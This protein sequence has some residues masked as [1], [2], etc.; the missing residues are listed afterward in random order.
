MSVFACGG[1]QNTQCI[2][3]DCLRSK[4][5]LAK[6]GEKPRCISVAPD[7][8]AT[9][10]QNG[11]QG[12]TRPIQIDWTGGLHVHSWNTEAIS[13]LAQICLLEL[14][15]DRTTV[16][17]FS[18]MT[19]NLTHH[20]V[21]KCIKAKLNKIGRDV[22]RAAEQGAENLK[23]HQE[24]AKTQDRRTTRRNTVSYCFTSI[25]IELKQST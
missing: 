9:F 11:T 1:S 17:Q 12:P 3:W 23:V 10:L 2:I 22:R 25:M 21:Q 15:E 18:K 8:M 5:L 4:G 20:L 19:L 6:A 7:V 14:R 16:A 24:E 13:L